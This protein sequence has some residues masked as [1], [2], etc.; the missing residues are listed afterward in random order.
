MLQVFVLKVSFVSNVCC[1]HFDLMLHIFHKCM[2]QEYVQNVSAVS[3]LCCSKCRKS[4]FE[5]FQS[6]QSYVAISV[7][8][9][10]VASVLPGCVAYVSI[11]F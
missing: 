10:Q 6:F 8:M 4:M 3:V 5:I 7:F 11:V 2:S 1:K 9:L